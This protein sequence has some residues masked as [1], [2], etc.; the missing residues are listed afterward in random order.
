VVGR[1]P[2]VDPIQRMLWQSA[3]STLSTILVP[4]A[5]EIRL[6]VLPRARGVVPL[7]VVVVVG[8]VAGFST[9]NWARGVVVVIVVDVVVVGAQ[10][11]RFLPIVCPTNHPIFHD[12][13]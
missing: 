9:W 8:F 7:V 2:L 3:V 12:D 10:F 1:V 11:V 4:E 5:R 6:V 13:C